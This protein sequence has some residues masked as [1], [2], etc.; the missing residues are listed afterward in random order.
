MLT[1]E[2]INILMVFKIF[3]SLTFKQIKTLTKEKSNSI[4]QN[5]IK[6][7]QRDGLIKI[8]KIGN[9]NT[10]SLNLESNLTLSYLNLIT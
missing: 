10:Y 3:D 6:E 2:Q 7:F 9:V 1:K 4:T 5:A 8:K